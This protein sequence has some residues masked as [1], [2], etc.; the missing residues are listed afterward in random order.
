MKAY[1]D[2]K[3]V[4]RTSDI[5]MGDTVL[6]KL[7]FE[8]EP[9][10]VQYCKGSQV[11]A[12]RKDGSTITRSTAHFKKVLYQSNGETERLTQAAETDLHES[13]VLYLLLI[14]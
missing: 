2:N 11:V 14:Q 7:P 1:A 5:Q 6:I 13:E 3:K 8:E 12:K 9:L 10:R 4:V